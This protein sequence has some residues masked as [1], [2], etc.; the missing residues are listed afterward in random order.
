MSRDGIRSATQTLY[1]DA[2]YS[3]KALFWTAT[4]WRRAHFFLGV[5][6]VIV[7]ALAG[8]ALVQEYPSTAILFT[9]IAAVFT[10]LLTFLEPH[11]IFGQ[12]HEFG[13]EYG[14]LRNK[15]AR[16]KDI[17]LSGEFDA[18]RMRKTLE[19]LAFEKGELQKGAPH[20][21]GIAYYFAKRSI[22][23]GQHQPDLAV[24]DSAH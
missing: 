13:V 12:Y 3:E 9:A 17:D 14:I 24:L 2:L 16:F 5:P 23:A 18:S 20:T 22:K 4:Q 1:E 10:A 21:G 19:K 15:V 11:K 6:S 8:A 7:S